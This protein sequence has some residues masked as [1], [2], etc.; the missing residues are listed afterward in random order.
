M[1]RYRRIVRQLRIDVAV[2]DVYDESIDASGPCRQCQEAVDIRNCFGIDVQRLDDFR[3]ARIIIILRIIPHLLR[4]SSVS[5]IDIP[6]DP[7]I[8][9][10]L[11]EF[12]GD[13]S[14]GYVSGTIHFIVIHRSVIH[15]FMIGIDG[16]FIIL[17]YPSRDVEIVIVLGQDMVPERIENG[18]PHAV[19]PAFRKRIIEYKISV[20]VQLK[21]TVF[22]SVD[23]LF[24]VFDVDQGASCKKHGFMFLVQHFHILIVP[25]QIIRRGLIIPDLDEKICSGSR[26]HQHQYQY[27][28]S[29]YFLSYSSFFLLFHPYILT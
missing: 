22:C 25:R 2:L 21:L 1:H 20:S 18:L 23:I 3:H 7:R 15:E 6:V 4:I 27:Q 29:Q 13:I 26:H 9:I 8:Q 24:L 19:V 11:I 14:A 12:L 28:Q 10:C 5:V 17:E 16:Q